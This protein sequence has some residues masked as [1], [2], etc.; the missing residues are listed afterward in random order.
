M[1]KIVCSTISI[2]DVRI[3]LLRRFSIYVFSCH[4][5]S[6][7]CSSFNVW[8]WVESRDDSSFKGSLFD[9][10]LQGHS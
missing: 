1:L 5:L 6:S 4:V 3:Y 7:T 9:P 8:D 10:V 2:C